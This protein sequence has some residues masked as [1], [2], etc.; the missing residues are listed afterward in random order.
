MSETIPVHAKVRVTLTG[1]VVS[2]LSEVEKYRVKLEGMTDAIGRPR[3]L[4]VEV[5]ASDLKVVP[6]LP[7]GEIRR[8]SFG[9]LW[10][11]MDKTLLESFVWHRMTGY[12]QHPRAAG[13]YRTDRQVED[14]E[15]VSS[16]TPE[17]PVLYLRDKDGDTWIEVSLG[18]FHCV[19]DPYEP[20]TQAH[21]D[22]ARSISGGPGYKRDYIEGKWGPVTEH[23]FTEE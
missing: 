14:F 23:Y 15:V 20:V 18:Y 1:T 3:D 19:G 12:D 7:P 16:P 10:V 2:K 9:H 21:L 11:R 4:R 8:D 13:H 6:G 22:E 17:K 5:E